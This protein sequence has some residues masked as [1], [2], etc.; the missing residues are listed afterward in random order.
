[1]ARA[2]KPAGKVR[3]RKAPLSLREKA[4]AAAAEQPVT[5]RQKAFSRAKLTAKTAAKPLKKAYAKKPSL[6]NN[7]A[8]TVVG[9]LFW[10]L[11]KVVGLLGPVYFVNSWREVRQVTWPTR[12]ETWRLTLAVFVF[13]VIFGLAAY[14]VDTVLDFVFKR[15][16]LK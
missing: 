12:R 2:D 5:R 11:K 3:I 14:G 1:M 7:R 9:K 13:S 6:P 16:V 4:A 15:T 8:T 10:P